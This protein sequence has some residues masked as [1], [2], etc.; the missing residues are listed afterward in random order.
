MRIAPATGRIRLGRKSGAV[1]GRGLIF[2]RRSRAALH[3]GPI[4]IQTFSDRK[5]GRITH[6]EKMEDWKMRAGTSIRVRLMLLK[7]SVAMAF[8]WHTT[9][10]DERPDVH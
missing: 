6:P 5:A 2:S 1:E 3:T 7:A 9:N 8:A 10:L 4:R